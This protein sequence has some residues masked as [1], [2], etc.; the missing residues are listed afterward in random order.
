M[1]AF[2]RDLAG[3]GRS[4]A[5]ANEREKGCTIPSFDLLSLELRPMSLTTALGA[6]L[7][8]LLSWL[9]KYLVW[10]LLAATTTLGGALV[11]MLFK[12]WTLKSVL[13]SLLVWP[14]LGLGMF[15]GLMVA[16]LPL[17]RVY[18]WSAIGGGLLYNLTLLLA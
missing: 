9:L 1:S 17:G 11:V 6:T 15:L 5:M 10:L 18:F 8:G 12:D 2:G 3:I 14:A 13:T 4:A 7:S 16:L